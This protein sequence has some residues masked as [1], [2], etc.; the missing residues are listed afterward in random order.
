[1][2]LRF[3]QHAYVRSSEAVMKVHL[4]SVKQSTIAITLCLPY[5][6]V[7]VVPMV[8]DVPFAALPNVDQ[9]MGAECMDE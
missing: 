1:V 9:I 7:L 4:Q 8:E 5:L 6:K 3:T 2:T